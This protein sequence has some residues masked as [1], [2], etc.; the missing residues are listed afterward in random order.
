[1]ASSKTFIEIEIEQ[2]EKFSSLLDKVNAKLEKLDT[3]LTRVQQT[4]KG[5]TFKI[6]GIKDL[7]R[8]GLLVETTGQMRDRL[9]A[10]DRYLKLFVS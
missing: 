4:T 10:F 6:Q 2:A 3:G 5:M 1:M 8:L 7:E 9:Y